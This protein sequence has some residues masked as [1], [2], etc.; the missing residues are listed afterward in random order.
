MLYS[1]NT[2]FYIIDSYI[3]DIKTKN[4]SIHKLERPT[5]DEWISFF[6]HLPDS[7]YYNPISPKPIEVYMK[8]S[9]FLES[10][11][12]LICTSLDNNLK[13]RKDTGELVTINAKF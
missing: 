13:I 1:P 10:P 2:G 3:E 8:D 9:T 12:Y 11:K 6:T 4:F 5:K 7:Y